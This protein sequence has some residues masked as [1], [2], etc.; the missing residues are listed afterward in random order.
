[1][2]EKIK[3]RAKIAG[4]EYTIIGN[5]STEHMN[6]VVAVANQHFQT[7]AELAPHLSVADRG[8]LMA[9]NAISDQLQQE[10]RIAELE[11]QLLQLQQ[12]KNDKSERYTIPNSRSKKQ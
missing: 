4:K 3:F 6:R 7:L 11:Q 9:I 1:M 8:M 12:D 10:A 2:E 5:R